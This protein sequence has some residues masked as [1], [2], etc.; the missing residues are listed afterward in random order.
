MPEQHW[1]GDV[2]VAPTVVQ[3]LEAHAPEVHRRLQHWAAS[4]QLDPGPLH[5][6]DEVHRPE[7]HTLEQQSWLVRQ[8]SPPS[9]HEGGGAGAAQVPAGQL[10][11]QHS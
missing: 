2:Q 11:E 8:A 7:A 4:S 1:A 6:A 5:T 10:P 9:R 3:V